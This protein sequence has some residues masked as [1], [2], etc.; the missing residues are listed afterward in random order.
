MTD[1]PDEAA[2]IVTPLAARLR[3]ARMAVGRPPRPSESV[4]RHREDLF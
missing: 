1:R 2:A 3:V 4:A